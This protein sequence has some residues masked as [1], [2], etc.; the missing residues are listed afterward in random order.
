MSSYLFGSEYG[1]D[2]IHFS[3]DDYNDPNNISEINTIKDRETRILKK[4]QDFNPDY[5]LVNESLNKRPVDPSLLNQTMEYK[6]NIR[7]NIIKD[8]E[9]KYFAGVELTN[10]N[11][12]NSY[13]KNNIDTI[14]SDNQFNLM[15]Q[16]Q[17]SQVKLRELD[18]KNNILI[19]IIFILIIYIIT[20]LNGISR[21]NNDFI[22]NNVK[23]KI[24]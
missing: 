17:V 14:K 6:S 12:Y 23:T 11:A 22:R 13:K 4:L 16:H 18:G 20:T 9:N 8:I 3:S 19:M 5:G 15:L 21:H 2:Q 24:D 10:L 1:T 7:D